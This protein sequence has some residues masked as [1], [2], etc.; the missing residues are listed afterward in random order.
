MPHPPRLTLTP[1]GRFQDWRDLRS[2][3]LDSLPLPQDYFVELQVRRAQG[4]RLLVGP[5]PVGH[6]L[7]V[8]D[9][10]VEFHLDGAWRTHADALFAQ[11]VDGLGLRK[12]L[13]KSFDLPWLSACLALQRAATVVGVLFR[14]QRPAPRI[15]PAFEPA[16]RLA[17]PADTDAVAAIDEHLFDSPEELEQIVREQHLFLF[18]RERDLLGFGLFLPV[19][20]GRPDHDIGMLVNARFRGHGLGKFILQHLAGHCRTQGLRPVAGCEAGNVASRRSL[21]AV[22][23]VADHRLVEFLLR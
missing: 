4:Y 20:E 15:V 6:L 22:G 17:R 19:I 12:A 21:E 2:A 16:I 5:E 1:L 13:C 11:A 9:T 7:T 3:Y 10:A 23:F 18:E 8:E 14:E